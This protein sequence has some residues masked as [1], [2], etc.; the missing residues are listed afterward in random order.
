MKRFFMFATAVALAAAGLTFRSVPAHASTVQVVLPGQSIQAAVNAASPGDTIELVPG[1]YRQSVTITT[2]GITLRGAG[3]GPGGSVLLPPPVP[4]PGFC[5]QVPPDATTHGGGICVF[6]AFDPTT[7]VVTRAVSDVHITGIR[8][9]DE[10][11]DGV[12]AYGTSGLRVDHVAVVN[13][14]VY[15][16]VAIESQHAT[17][18]DNLVDG[19]R[20]T[21]GAGMFMGYTSHADMLITG[22]KVRNATLG[23]FVSDMQDVRV[24][25][26]AATGNCSG[27]IVLDDNHPI[28]GVSPGSVIG[29]ILVADNV[30]T[31]NNAP[32]LGNPPIQGAG[33]LLIGTQNTTVV[34]NR[35]TANR[36]AQTL[37]GGIVLISA[38][39][40]G[41]LNEGSDVIAH[42]SA[43][44]N[45][46]FDMTWDSRGANVVFLANRCGAASP[47]GLC[48][49]N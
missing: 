42:N 28:D 37:S 11:G 44:G 21:S 13:T 7:G 29:D 32:C 2:D 8:V 43:S 45:S 47:A 34:G 18:A 35:A 23:I 22:N 27:A 46:P 40:Y 19:V 26:N 24:T 49:G 15:G 38:V 41:G 31:A 33:L 17:L 20:S 5:S 39:P 9:E 1:T 25:H 3:A 10:P 36:G 48:A 14:G 16:I 12:G 30:F 4:P 6:G